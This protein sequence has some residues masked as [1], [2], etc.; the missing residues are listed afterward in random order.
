MDRLCDRAQFGLAAKEPRRSGTGQ[1]ASSDGG[2]C[3]VELFPGP[4]RDCSRFEWGTHRADSR[5]THVA[6]RR[7]PGSRRSGDCEY[8]GRRSHGP[9]CCVWG[10]LSPPHREL[11][12]AARLSALASRGPASLPDLRRGSFS[13]LGKAARLYRRSWKGGSRS[14]LGRTETLQRHP[15]DRG[16]YVNSDYDWTAGRFCPPKA[17]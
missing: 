16:R 14:P 12:G 7:G 1:L 2:R 17:R 11:A 13:R 10:H 6:H 9:S 4:S 5:R 15:L 3:S 8:G